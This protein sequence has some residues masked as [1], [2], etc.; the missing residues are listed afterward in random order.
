MKN[1]GM[2][3]LLLIV[4]MNFNSDLSAQKAISGEES[5][6]WWKYGHW[7]KPKPNPRA[8]SLPLI[9]VSGTRFVNSNGDTILFRG[10]NISD[11]D[12]IEMEG[13]WN[14]KHFEKVKEIVGISLAQLAFGLVFILGAGI[15]SIMHALKL[16]R[17][18]LVGTIRTFVQLFLLVGSTAIGTLLVVYLVRKLCFGP[19][20]RLLLQPKNL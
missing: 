19:G 7:Q 9:Q 6:K 3:I 2:F 15:A 1:A 14:K 17:D 13:Q 20:E 11:P 8:K 5:K 18:L 4:F 12:K 16:E 10:I